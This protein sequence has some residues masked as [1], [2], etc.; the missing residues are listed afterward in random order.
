[1][2]SWDVQD[3]EQSS[4]LLNERCKARCDPLWMGFCIREYN[5]L[6]GAEM[7]CKRGW[8]QSVLSYLSQRE[9]FLEE[10][11]RTKARCWHA[12]ASQ[13]PRLGW[14]LDLPPAVPCSWLDPTMGGVNL[15]PLESLFYVPVS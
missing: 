4:E 1:M 12:K 14:Y 7:C 9:S 10:E 6:Y 5:V 2:W 13:V 8:E 11:R 15:P 3:W